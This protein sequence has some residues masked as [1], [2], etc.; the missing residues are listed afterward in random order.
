MLSVS[1]THRVALIGLMLGLW[2]VGSTVASQPTERSLALVNGRVL[3]MTID[4]ILVGH[5]VLVQDDRI[6]E[7]GPDGS[8]AIPDEAEVVDLEG[9]YVMP[10][11]IDAHVHFFAGEWPTYEASRLDYL[12]HGIT[13]VLNQW[14]P[15]NAQHYLDIRDRSRTDW[16]SPTVYTTGEALKTQRFAGPAEAEAEVRRQVRAGFDMLKVYEPNRRETFDRIHEVAAE[17]GIPTIGHVPDALGTET[18]LETK[19]TIS[20]ASELLSGWQDHTDAGLERLVDQVSV[21]GNW[22]Q[23]T[24]VVTGKKAQRLAGQLHRKGVP[25]VLGTD[26]GVTGIHPGEAVHRELSLL[27]EAGLRPFDALAAATVHAG[28]SLAGFDQ[29]G[30]IAP[31]YRADLLIM[32]ENPLEVGGRIYP[33]SLVLRG[34]HRVMPKP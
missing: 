25:L 1:T 4:T 32:E 12:R 17:L 16:L 24:L 2:G 3:P 27:M 22:V 30:V 23:T 7:L 21:S 9:A 28:R 15:G 8:L 11:L 5:T 10:G 34:M 14:A 13:T 29:A 18:V 20:H 33:R 31:G 6:A 26:T 19:Q